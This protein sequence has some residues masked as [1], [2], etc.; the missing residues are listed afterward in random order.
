MEKWRPDF[1]QELLDN[2][3]DGV[4]YVDPDRRITFWNK[5]AEVITGYSRQEV[6]GRH[7]SDN[8]LKHVDE[9]GVSLC[10]TACPL[11]HAVQ[12]GQPRAATVYL[13]HKNGHRLPVAVRVT[14]RRNESGDIRGAVEVFSDN[15]EKVAAL[16]RLHELEALAYLDPLTGIANR[17]YLEFFLAARFNELRRFGWPFGLAFADIDHFKQVNNDHGHQAGDL[18]LKM[19]ANTLAQN[20]RSFDLVGRWGG[21]EFLCVLSHIGKPQELRQAT[22]RLR[23]LVA[24]SSIP[25]GEHP[26]SVTLSVG[27]TLVRPDDDLESV[28]RR[29]DRLLYQSKDAGRNCSHFG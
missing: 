8:L 11:A 28:T 1:C 10:L 22:E 20:C 17:R 26:V 19:V 3:Y 12:D 15:S 14:P 18:V 9:Q 4:Y 24:N 6:L 21:E 13:H 29:V 16:Q 5:A 7:C 27:A 23:R 25:S 2:L